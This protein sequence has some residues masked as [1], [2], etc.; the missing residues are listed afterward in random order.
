MLRRLRAWLDS[1]WE[2]R[3]DPGTTTYWYGQQPIS[4][5]EYR[6]LSRTR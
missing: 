2:G 5:A 6:H 4:A 1:R 3:D